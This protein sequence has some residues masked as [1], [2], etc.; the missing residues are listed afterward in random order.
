MNINDMTESKY[1]KKSDVDPVPKLVTISHL[2]HE[3]LA[4][5]THEPEMK[6]VLH[7][8]EPDIKPMVLNKINSQLIAKILGSLETDDWTG[9]QVVLY[10]DPSVSFGGQLTGG[11]RVRASRRPQSHPAP[12]PRP[13]DA[14]VTA[15]P[16]AYDQ[17][18]LEDVDIPF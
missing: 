17:D 2:T 13:Q 6:F 9:K 4:L 18:P 11:I 10:N 16:V 5:D 1:L 12:V 15:P 7:F 8:L 14:V 3:N